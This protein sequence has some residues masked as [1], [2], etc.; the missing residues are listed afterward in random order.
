MPQGIA[1]TQATFSSSSAPAK[2]LP[3]RSRRGLLRMVLE[4]GGPGFCQF[5]LNNACNARCGFCN[6]ALDKLPRES[7]KYVDRGRALDAIDILYRQGIR[8]LV[9]TGGEPL[10][11]PDLTTIVKRATDLKMKVMLVTNAGLLKPHRIRE[12]AEA[13]LSSFIISID[14]ASKEAHERNRGLPGVCE[15]IREAN[16]LITE[17]K[18]HATA[19]VTM[20][21]LVDYEALPGFLTDLGFSSVTFS[22]PL[23]QLGSNFLGYSDSELVNYTTAELLEAFEQIKR[24]KKRFLVINPTPSIEEMQRFLRHEEQRFPC[25]GGYKFFYLDWNLDLWR[26]HYWEKP[27]CSIYEFDDS[28]RVR[29]GCTRC[30]IDCYRDSSVMQHIGVAVHDAYAALRSGR[31]REA[32]GAVGRPGN[33]GSLRAVLEELPWLLRF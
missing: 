1:Q 5:A 9:I 12:L 8:Y 28:Q 33:L 19:S 11:H 27:L 15:R 29:D 30:M 23:T 18:L 3:E 20:S 14:A 7:W 32:A 4:E 22:Y 31:L 6:F 26:C 17:L 16:R 13:G 2:P 25:L 10:L 21:R 24:L